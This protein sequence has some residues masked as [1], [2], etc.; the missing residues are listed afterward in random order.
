HQMNQF[1][2]AWFSLPKFRS[3]SSVDY[4]RTQDRGSAS[5]ADQT[6]P[7]RRVKRQRS[8][9]P[10]PPRRPVYAR[11]LFWLTLLLSAGL[12]GGATRGY[13]VWKSVEASVPDTAKAL[14][15]ERGGTVTIKSADNVVLQ[16]IGPAARETLKYEQLPDHLV[17]AF[18][19][20]EDSRFYEHHGIDYKGIARAV[21][22][23]VQQREVVEG[24]STITQQ[25][26]RIVFLDQDRTLQ[27]KVKEA[28][29]ATKLEKDLTKNQIIERY[30]N[31]VYLGAGAYGVADAAWIYFGKSP[32]DLTL[33]ESA[34]IAG[35]APAPSVYSPL[36]NPEAA[37]EQR[38]R[39]ISRMLATNA[40]TQAEADE[41]LTTEISTKPKEP[42]FL[43][44]EY[45]YFT[46]YVQKQLSELLSPEQLEEGGL[47]VETTLNVSWQ[48]AAEAAVEEAISI[49]QRQRFGQAALVAVDPRNGEIKAMVGGNDF[50]ESQF[51]RVT[52]AQRQ[53]GSTFKAFVYTTAIAAGFSPYK[54][55]V[56]AKYVVDGYEPKNYGDSYSGNVD[57]VK[58]LQSSI[59][60]VAVKVL[61][62]VGFDPVVEMAKRMGIQSKLLPAYSLALGSSEV[63]LLELTSAYGTL[64][65]KGVHVP[66]HGIRRV[67]NSRGEV[68]YQ[69]K[70][71]PARAVDA[72]TAAIMTWMLRGVVEGGTGRNAA[73]GR[74]VAGKTGTSE[75]NRDLW[76]VG[77]IPQLVA[78]VWLGNDNSRPTRGA[79]SSAAYIWR[80]FMRELV[81]DIPAEQ[82]PE[83]PSLRGRKGTIEA[84]PVKPRRVSAAR[85]SDI[86]KNERSRSR[87]ERSEDSPPPA[88]YEREDSG[89][90]TPR[91][92]SNNDEPERSNAE[93][94]RP[95]RRPSSNS[96]SRPARDPEPAP[97]PADVAPAPAPPAP[98]PAP[99]PEAPPAPIPAPA[100]APPPVND[101]PPAPLP[102]PQET[103]SGTS[104]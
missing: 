90:S 102:A 70:N 13:R 94:E 10:P 86:N 59:N 80:V 16:K 54:D 43:Y 76:F 82:F 68:I 62:D 1:L 25:L 95:S 4:S 29:L 27:R 40:I 89:R 26:A 33:A 30:L 37:R 91:N 45:P 104:E 83:R 7:S 31:L 18:I 84:K 57:M 64:A 101:A 98:A 60:I 20:S 77:Y 28:I 74:P 17:Q 47:V 96:N 61:V 3:P 81:D 63:N 99:P 2:A 39:V 78:G 58:A 46:I 87:E 55:Y 15:Y 24:A 8:S 50:N 56:D 11:P 44:S 35:M 85:A 103:N 21:L 36:V 71:Q 72:D 22:A 93:P 32:Q 51:N 92:E 52:Q 100:P 69:L 75:R 14:T 6:K 53:P 48:K 49:G 38:D 42:K 67:L 5:D 41:A 97:A 9:S 23:N 88:S 66:A 34:L 73:L 12:A 65:N 79:S 19:A